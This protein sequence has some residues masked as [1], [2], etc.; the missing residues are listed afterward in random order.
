[1]IDDAA[2]PI[3]KESLAVEVQHVLRIGY[4]PHD[5]FHRVFVA[6]EIVGDR[7]KAPSQVIELVTIDAGLLA[8]IVELVRHA[9][10]T[11]LALIA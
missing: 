4:V 8:Q 3:V 1:M 2:Q 6:R 11:G 10:A 9:M 7:R 5:R